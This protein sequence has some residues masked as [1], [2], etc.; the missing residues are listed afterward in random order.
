MSAIKEHP[1]FQVGD[2]VHWKSQA[3]A[4]WI[5][6]QGKIIKVVPPYFTVRC[7]PYEH[8]HKL[9]FDGGQRCQESYLVEV[10][11]GSTAKPKLYWPRSS[12]LKK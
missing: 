3:N 8:T 4:S 6:K 7:Y 9:M 10:Q 12:K 5:E 1:K 11:L 2:E